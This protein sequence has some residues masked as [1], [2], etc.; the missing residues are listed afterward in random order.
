VLWLHAK[1]AM[2]EA[3]CKLRVGCPPRPH[4]EKP[5]LFRQADGLWIQQGICGQYSD[6][7][8]RITT[9]NAEVHFAHPRIRATGYR[10]GNCLLK[11]A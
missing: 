7:L 2:V 9:V 4:G 1:E 10:V 8:L 3:R 6:P 11:C 5:A